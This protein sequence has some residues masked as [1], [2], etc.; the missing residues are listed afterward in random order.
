MAA[1]SKTPAKGKAD[2]KALSLIDDGRTKE[3]RVAELAVQPSLG[4]ASVTQAF[5]KGSFGEVDLMA[6]LEATEKLAKDVCGGNLAVAETMLIGQASALNMVFT[7]L[8]QRAAL[9]A[10]EY[11]QA[12][13]RYMRLALKAQ[14][15]C[16]ASL[17]ALA[18]IKNPPVVY[19][20]Q[21]NIANGPQQVNNAAHPPPARACGNETANVPNGLLERSGDGQ[22]LDG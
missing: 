11:P 2:P 15:Q 7:N 3:Q 6:T 21:A 14:A 10:G 12:F 1:K 5:A 22:R 9:N 13:E 19:A 17:E 18:A 16:R 8:S 20:R 4:I